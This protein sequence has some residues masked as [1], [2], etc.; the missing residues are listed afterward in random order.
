[1]VTVYVWLPGG[2]SSSS[3]KSL[4]HAAMQIAGMMPAGSPEAV[5]IL[6]FEGN[7]DLGQPVY[8]ETYIS[9]WPDP[10]RNW[11]LASGGKTNTY[12]DDISDEGGMPGFR[13]EIQDRLDELEMRRYW[14]RFR[15]GANKRLWSVFQN[16]A[17]LVGHTLR[18][19]GGPFFLGDNVVWTP[20]QVK[21]YAIMIAFAGRVVG[22]PPTF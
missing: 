15:H 5:G 11:W 19:G 3:S 1:M 9:W 8:D 20:A 4:G 16:C 6:E 21:D 17:T 22:T 18:A 14:W 2:S 7:K 12:A 10:N 13:L